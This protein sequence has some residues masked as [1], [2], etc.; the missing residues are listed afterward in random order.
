MKD[1]RADIRFRNNTNVMWDIYEVTGQ[2]LTI[3]VCILFERR[4]ICAWNSICNS[5]INNMELVAQG[6][7]DALLIQYVIDPPGI[8]LKFKEYG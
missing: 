5:T 4:K 2:L 6:W 8:P 7:R 1:R 3:E